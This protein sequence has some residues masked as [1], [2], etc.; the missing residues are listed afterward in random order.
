MRGMSTGNLRIIKNQFNTGSNTQ[1]MYKSDKI[2]C[3][4]GTIK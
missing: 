2:Q 4:K 3:L 1:V